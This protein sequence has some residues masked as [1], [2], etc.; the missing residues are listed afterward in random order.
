MAYS[1][2]CS[3]TRIILLFLFFRR[4]KWVVNSRCEGLDAKDIGTRT[5]CSLHFQPTAYNNPDQWSSARLLPTAL[6]TII[7]C[8]NPPPDPTPR[9][10]PPKERLQPVSQRKRKRDDDN[11]TIDTIVP[12]EDN[13]PLIEDV[14][15][16]I[17]PELVEARKQIEELKKRL[18]DQESTHKEKMDIERVRS[19]N[20]NQQLV[21]ALKRVVKR[22]D[23]IIKVSNK[24]D[25]CRKMKVADMLEDL[26]D[27][28]K[29]VIE[30]MLKGG[31]KIKWAKHPKTLDLCL[32]LFFRSPAA[33][34]HLRVCGFILPHPSTLQKRYRIVMQKAGFCPE[35]EKMLKIRAVSLKE[36]EKL[37]TIAMDGMTVAAHLKY[38]KDKDSVSGFEDLGKKGKSTKV[39]NEGVAV[40][41]RGITTPWKQVIGYFLTDHCLTSTQVGWIIEEAVELLKRVGLT[42]V[43]AVMDQ[44]STQWKWVTDN[45][46]C[47]FIA[48]K[49]QQL[50]VFIL[51]ITGHS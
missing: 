17:D 28:P 3:G 10:K 18:T 38:C 36:H 35:L 4:K 49:I 32:Q 27:V 37:V 5:V 31:K 9:R 44:G 50:M 25:E 39:A 48:L 42:P 45:K 22:D 13:I 30:V 47:L 19:K 34:K 2:E 1:F 12:A 11:E 26:P 46:V 20:L 15:K 43:A 21:R 6:P 40:M 41:V 14:P 51:I 8:P 7:A 16:Q 23:E 24:L 33:Y 29:A